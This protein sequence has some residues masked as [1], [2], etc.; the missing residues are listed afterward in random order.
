MGSGGE[1]MSLGSSLGSEVLVGREVELARLAALREL[2]V[3]D[4]PAEQMFDEIVEL[5]ASLWHTPMAL[6]SLVDESRQ[7]FK[8]R[9]GLAVRETSREVAFCAH[10][11]L[12]PREVLIVS[13]TRL[14]P[15]FQDNP[16]VTGDP[17]LRFYAGAPILT[18]D[19]YAMGTVCVLDRQPRE[20]SLE[21]VQVLARLAQHAATLLEYRRTAWHRQSST[22]SLMAAVAETLIAG[23]PCAVIGRD[24]VVVHASIGFAALWGVPPFAL[25]G[26]T[27][28]ERLP[29]QDGYEFGPH[30]AAAQAGAVLRHQHTLASG[31]GPPR[32]LR[33]VYAPVIDDERAVVG[34]VLRVSDLGEVVRELVREREDA[35][36]SIEQ[37]RHTIERLAERNAALQRFV[38]MVAHD[39]REPIN[40]I[41]NF[42][43]LLQRRHTEAFDESAAKYLTFVH[44]GGARIRT[45]LEDLLALVRLDG[46]P[47]RPI[48]L[49]LGELVRAAIAD[50]SALIERT[51]AQVSLG[52]LPIVRADATLIRVV[53]QNLLGNA[54]KFHR[55]GEAP[56]VSVTGGRDER[57]W[58][59]AVADQGIGIAREHLPQLFV[60]FRRLHSRREYEGTGLGLAICQRIAELHGGQISVRSVEGEGSV[61]TLAVPARE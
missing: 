4:T 60:E 57:G 2:A 6:V 24:G 38:R 5:A 21:Q 56:Q 59:V 3:L 51:G 27:L 47:L 8:A 26:G 58:Y 23:E 17:W 9:V 54:L 34:A 46:A 18:R 13:D 52:E 14:D 7:W 37:Q 19:G 29:T 43:Q 44:E 10:A 1:R 48:E 49:G 36:G 55:P 31:V 28:D 16:L 45:M 32:Y 11:I 61:F 22:R 20:P 53:M 40:T 42:A 35:R 39:V 50:L 15:R 33:M 41:C 12:R 25:E 30:L